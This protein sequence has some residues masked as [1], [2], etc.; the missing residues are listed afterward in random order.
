MCPELPITPIAAGPAAE[1]DDAS[2]AAKGSLSKQTPGYQTAPKSNQLA[3]HLQASIEVERSQLTRQLHDD[4]GGLL[5]GA[6][7]DVAWVE[8]RLQS[9]ELQAKLGRARDS[10][11]AAVDLKR[12][13]IEGM[14]PT[15]LENVGIFAAMRWH[16]AKHCAA[17]GLECVANF[18]LTEPVLR[19]QVAIGIYRITEEALRLISGPLRARSIRLGA[20][21]NGSS[22]TVQFS[23]DGAAITDQ[24]LAD[25]TEFKSMSQRISTLQGRFVTRGPEDTLQWQLVVPIDPQIAEPPT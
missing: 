20:E 1:P 10:L 25:L 22:L 3:S 23:H 4:L 13:L 21:V 6:L 16:F 14:R 17:A 18:P 12:N 19:P 8:A 11:R 2:A 5:V 9:P 24:Q 7:M 15:L